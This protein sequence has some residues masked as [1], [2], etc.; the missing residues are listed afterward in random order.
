MNE[1]AVK[2]HVRL[3]CARLGL[4]M[5]RNNVGACI[6]D[7]GRQV[8]YGL[9]NE[10]AQLNRKI[11]SSDL[12]G[13]T[14]VKI[15]PHHV[16]QR[17]G[18]FTAFETKHSDW[19]FSPSDERAVAQLKFIDLVREAGGIGYFISDPMQVRSVVDGLLR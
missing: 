6:D 11:K 8:R 2:S 14:T 19:E 3:E 12:I 5:W 17:F 4:Q 9:A 18:L 10:S 1:D 16:G 13:I 7:T 15:M